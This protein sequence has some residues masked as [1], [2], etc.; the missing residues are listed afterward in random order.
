MSLGPPAKAI[1]TTLADDNC[2]LFILDEH[3]G[4]KGRQLGAAAHD[5][6]PSVSLLW[7]RR[8]FG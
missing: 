1:T 7:R 5:R 3:G 2:T 8:G 6:E 4:A